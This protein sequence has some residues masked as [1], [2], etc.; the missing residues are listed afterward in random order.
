VTLDQSQ[1]ALLLAK[2][3]P[4]ESFNG[5]LVAAVDLDAVTEFF[6]RVAGNAGASASLVGSD[7]SLLLRY[8]PVPSTALPA[9]APLMAAVR[10]AQTGVFRGASDV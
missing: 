8:P 3:R 1:E 7:A 4:G 5:V 6:A 9:D 2:R 10:R